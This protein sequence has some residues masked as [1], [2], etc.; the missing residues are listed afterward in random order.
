MCLQLP[1]SALTL[2]P[3]GEITVESEVGM[4][5]TFT[6]WLPISQDGVAMPVEDERHGDP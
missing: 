6:V 5:S 3:P 2:R 1:H 4:G